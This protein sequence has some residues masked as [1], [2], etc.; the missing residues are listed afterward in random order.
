MNIISIRQSPEYAEVAI[1][2]F[3][4]KWNSVPRK[5]YDDSI[6]HAIDSPSPLPQ[7][8]LLESGDG[9]IGC[10]GL[11]TND[12]NSRMDLW[13]WVCGLFIEAD[14]RGNGYGSLLLEKAKEDSLRTGFGH[15]YLATGHIG[16]YEKYGFE[17]LGQ[18]YHPWEEES[19]VYSCRLKTIEE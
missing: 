16:F 14:F 2:Y 10:A 9:I 5:V 11:I 18:A 19:R 3:S 8:Y 12:F 6:R 17:Y 13:P 15:L 4:S 1:R 7:W